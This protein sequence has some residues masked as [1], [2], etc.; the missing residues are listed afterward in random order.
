[1]YHVA[2]SRGPKPAELSLFH[3]VPWLERSPLRTL[4]STRD[5]HNN[6]MPLLLVQTLIV[7]DFAIE[8]PFSWKVVSFIGF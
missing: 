7:G 8:N 4:F 6:M 1:M 2:A 3:S 5:C